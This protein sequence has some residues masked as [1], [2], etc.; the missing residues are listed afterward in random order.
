MQRRSTCRSIHTITR[1]AFV[2]VKTLQGVGNIT[3]GYLKKMSGAS[4][5]YESHINNLFALALRHLGS[6]KPFNMLDLG[7]GDGS[8]TIRVA[9][10]FM[11]PPDR[12]HGVDFNQ[13]HIDQC[14]RH[15]NAHVLDLEL[16]LIPFADQTFDLVVCNQVFE[17]LKNYQ[18]VLRRMIGITKPGGYILIG[19]PNLAH[20]IN[21]LYLLVGIQP[22]CIDI[23]SSH[24]RGFTHQSFKQKL[25][26][27]LGI[28]Y[29]DCLGSE[30]IYPL[31]LF[32]ARP[33]SNLF[34]GLCAYICYLVRKN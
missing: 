34:T 6:F 17:H 20:L 18:C 10:Y 2:E 14:R 12:T 27:E 1:F 28:T 8:R 3:A 11:I 9:E 21:R 22:M 33:L 24:V 29:I 26:S 23:D 16:D 31:P 32:L 5:E 13:S 15:F 4:C 30:L 7:C 19:I 25:K